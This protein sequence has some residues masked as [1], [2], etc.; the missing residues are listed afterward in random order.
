MFWVP[1][2]NSFIQTQFVRKNVPDHVLC[3]D[4]LCYFS[5][6]VVTVCLIIVFIVCCYFFRFC[7]VLLGSGI[8]QRQSRGDKRSCT[9]TPSG[10]FFCLLCREFV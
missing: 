5:C 2:R 1:G 6:F 4:A 8:Y 10:R 3:V 9:T 7:F